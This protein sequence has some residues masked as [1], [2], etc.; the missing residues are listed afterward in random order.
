[1]DFIIIIVMGGLWG[2]F[3]NVCI[4][5]LPLDKGVVSGRSYCPRCKKQI[6]WYDNIPIFSYL[7]IQGK[8]RK[9]KNKISVQYLVVELLNILS[10]ATVYFF[11]GISI[12]TVLLM[13]LALVFVIIFF[14][15]L[16]HYII[17]DSLTFPLM[18]LGFLKSFDPNLNEIFPNYI[19]SLIGG[20]FGYGIIWLIIFFYK[21]L[22]NKEGMGLGD[23]KLLAAIGF[24]FGWIAIPFVIFSSSVIALFTVLP[25]LIN[26]SKKLSSIIPFGPFIIIGCILYI[27]FI[28]QYKNL[29]F[30]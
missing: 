10:F 8:C 7:F 4:Y 15:D 25:S 22:R 19:N 14:I 13:I 9:C 12:T 29:L 6:S 20:V 24:W 21:V 28:E 30:G 2:S 11:Y 5:R 16:K 18:V 1:V 3:S 26:K 23:A 17:P 27:I